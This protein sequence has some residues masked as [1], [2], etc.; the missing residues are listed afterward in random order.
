MGAS[1]AFGGQFDAYGE[2]RGPNKLGEQENRPGNHQ[3]T[4]LAIQGDPRALMHRREFH[5]PVKMAAW[6]NWQGG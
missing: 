4:A 5:L 3:M 6:S 1:Q 2:E